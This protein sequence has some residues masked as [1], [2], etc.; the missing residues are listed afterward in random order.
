MRVA[1]AGE[2]S[3]EAKFS[4]YL[5]DLGN[6]QTHVD[7]SVSQFFKTQIPNEYLFRSDNLSCFLIELKTITMIQNGL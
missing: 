3:D 1:M 7:K 4:K 5:L 6:G 2:N